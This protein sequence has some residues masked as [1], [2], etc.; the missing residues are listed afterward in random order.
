[1]VKKRISKPSI[2]NIFKTDTARGRQ[3]FMMA[4]FVSLFALIGVATLLQSRAATGNDLVVTSITMAPASPTTGQAVTF[5]A[6]VKNQGTTPTTAGTAVGVAFYVDNVRV[7][8]NQ[9][10]TNSLIAGASVTL[11]ANAGTPGA[12][13]TATSGPH[14]IRA[15]ADDANVI[16]DESNEANNS[17]ST[18]LTLGNTGTLYLSPATQSVNVGG[19]VTTTV[20]LTPG[21]T[22]DGVEATITYDQ[23]KLTFVSINGTGSPF[24]VELGPQTGGSGTVKLTR[25]NLGT[26]VSTD[27]LV[28]TVAFT[29]VAGSGTSTLQI[30]GNATK[31]GAYTNPSVTNSTVTFVTPDT[32]APVTTITA[33]AANASLSM[34]Q[35]VT[36]TATDAVGVT[37]VEFYM[38]GQLLAS[39]TAAPYSYSLDTTKYTT[40]THSLQ[41]KA[42]DA[43][44]NTGSSTAVSVTIKN[45]PEDINQDGIVNLLDFSA[46]VSKFGQS[47]TGIGR[48]DINGDGIVN[49]QDFSLL[50]SKFGQ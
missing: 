39:D 24:D 47:G 40:G 11:T 31:G 17:F 42:Y 38:D 1:M 26:G 15:V 44:G 33:P 49:L 9:T 14:T 37:K 3:A 50:V 4:L 43:A 23:T 30:T 20:R 6:V 41:T 25:G 2:K 35:S 45:F 7:S 5:T 27:S 8:W 21:V 34:T 32:V 19:T 46:L 16:P 22:V 36:A 10:N 48:S 12:T 13:W 28:A 29:A 18:T